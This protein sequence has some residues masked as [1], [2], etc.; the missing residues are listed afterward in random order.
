MLVSLAPCAHVGDKHPP[1][2]V[3]AVSYACMYGLHLHILSHHTYTFSPV[4]LTRGSYIHTYAY[5][6]TH[7]HAHA[8]AH[9]RTHA[10]THARTHTH[11]HMHVHTRTQTHTHTL[12]DDPRRPYPN[13]IEMRS[14]VLGQLSSPSPLAPQGSEGVASSG[15]QGGPSG[16]I[17]MSS[18][19]V[20]TR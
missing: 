17:L 18:E 4:I 8:H 7:A 16:S 14:G 13:D 2:F 19:A 3:G 12:P 10:R 11:A 9:T 20:R 1:F 15:T 5:A 6:Y